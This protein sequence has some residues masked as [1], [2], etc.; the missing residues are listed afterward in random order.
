MIHA[1]ITAR[2]RIRYRKIVYKSKSNFLKSIRGGRS[3]LAYGSCS[4]T[5]IFLWFWLARCNFSAFYCTT[6]IPVLFHIY[7]VNTSSPRRLEGVQAHQYTQGTGTQWSTMRKHGVD[8]R[9]NPRREASG[10]LFISLS[11]YW[12]TII[13]ILTIF[14]PMQ[15]NF[16]LGIR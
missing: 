1:Y 8:R 11:F 9:K 14:Q 5:C 15:D 12:L 2:L 13:S 7:V 10:F 3:G 4:G 16:Y 6:M